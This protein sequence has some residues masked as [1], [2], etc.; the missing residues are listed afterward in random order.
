MKFC[1]I[2]TSWIT[3]A[4]IDAANRSGDAQLAAVYSRRLETAQAFA[5]KHGAVKAYTDIKEMLEADE[6]DF[7][8]I[9]SPNILHPD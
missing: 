5:N 8:Y 4:F 9:A 1:T 2:G 7:V 6:C 3:E